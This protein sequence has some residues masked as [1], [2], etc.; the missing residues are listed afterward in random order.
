VRL[1][2]MAGVGRGK[3][4]YVIDPDIIQTKPGWN[5]RDMN[6]PET[7]AHIR[8]MADCI[9]ENG[10]AAFPPITVYQEED[11]IYVA[12]GHC[13]LEAHRIA[14]AEDAP[15]KG[16]TARADVLSEEDRVLDQLN[17]NSGL[18]LSTLEKANVIKRLCSFGWT[19]AEV[20][21]RTGNSVTHIENQLALAN[22]PQE[23]KTMVKENKVAARTA[24][25]VI[26]KEGATRA[27]D[28]LKEA[29]KTAESKG[30]TKATAKHI[31]KREPEQKT[32]TQLTEGA[33]TDW[34]TRGPLLEKAL[35]KIIDA[36]NSAKQQQAIMDARTL[37]K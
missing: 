5:G 23:I 27:T 34:S 17:S 21:K 33:G 29:V 16:I 12:A 35:R 8:R 30:K 37:V 3:D 28:T 19:L 32:F 2:D 20:A 36:E 11:I 22:A 26:R 25:D 4:E 9:K 1:K 15:I 31:P 6:S 10:T 24:T 7:Q 13:R 18:E 14:K